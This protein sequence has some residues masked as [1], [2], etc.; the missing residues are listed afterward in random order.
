MKTV[1]TFLGSTQVQTM[2]D[3]LYQM[4][5]QHCEQLRV[6]CQH[7]SRGGVEQPLSSTLELITQL[8]HLESEKSQLFE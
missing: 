4:L 1:F 2:V 7:L 3:E 6:Q 5:S 8:Q